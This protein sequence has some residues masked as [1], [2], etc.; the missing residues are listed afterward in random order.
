MDELGRVLVSL[1]SIIP[2]GLVVFFCSY[3]HLKK[4]YSYFEKNAILNK[5]IAKKKIFMEPK[6][7]SDVDSIL[8]NYTKSIKVRLRFPFYFN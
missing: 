7:T 4:T 6:R 1:C 8:T 2:D 5:I 3:D